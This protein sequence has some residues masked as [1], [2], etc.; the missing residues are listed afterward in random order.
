MDQVRAKMK[1]VKN[2]TAQGGEILLTPVVGGSDENKRFYEHTP[3]GSVHLNLL[4]PETA[5]FFKEECEYY[6]DFTE[7]AA[8]PLPAAAFSPAGDVYP[9]YRA[10]GASTDASNVAG[11]PR[12]ELEAALNE[13]KEAERLRLENERSAA[14]AKAHLP[15]P[16]AEVDGKAKK[17]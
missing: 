4:K 17:K 1:C 3:G 6:V 10:V 16:P 8:V 15:A 2:E 14:D 13:R 5:K 11:Q 12:H 7:A 9:G